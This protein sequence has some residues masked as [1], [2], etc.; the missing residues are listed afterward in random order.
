MITNEN[1]ENVLE[2]KLNNNGTLNN[3]DLKN[4]L[5][6]E[7]NNNGTINNEVVD[8]VPSKNF[9]NIKR[10][11][12]RHKKIQCKICF[13]TMQNNHSKRH[14]K[15]HP[16]L[17]PMDEDDARLEL[18][19]RRQVYEEKEKKQLKLDSIAREVGTPRECFEEDMKLH[20]LKP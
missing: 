19:S 4:V 13:K 2:M 1:L 20:G 15:Q 9:G 10:K 11:D 17:M 14:M 16:D 8:G 5:E 6:M 12:E 3:E 18:R 7:L